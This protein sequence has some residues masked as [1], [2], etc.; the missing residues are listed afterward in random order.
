MEEL[1]PKKTWERVLT[2]IENSI[3]KPNFNTWFKDTSIARFDDG[4]IFLSVPNHFVEEWLGSKFHNLILKSLRNIST[5]IHSLQ[6]IISKDDIRKN[7]QKDKP[8]LINKELP[9]ENY[10]INREDNLNPRYTFENFIVGPFNELA[11]AAS[12]AVIKK[13][14]IVYNPLFIYGNTGHGK[15]HLIQAIGNF[16]KNVGRKVFY[17]TSEKFGQEYVNALQMNKPNFFKEKYRKYDVLIMDDIQFFSGKMKIQEELFHLFNHLYDNNR[18]II[19][20]SDK[21][22]SFIQD[23]EERLRS[24]FS[25]GMVVDIPPPEAESRMAII[26]S[27]ISQGNVEVSDEIL[28]FLSYS[29]T[30]NIR[31]IEGIVNSIVCQIQLKRRDLSL[32]EVKM[33]I[34]NSTKPKKNISTKEIVKTVA[35]FYNIEENLIYEKTRKKEIIKPRQIIMYLLREEFAISYPAIGERL[36]GRDHTTVMHSCDK[37]KRDLEKDQNLSTEIDQ[38]RSILV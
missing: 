31:E 7:N 22:P 2:E 32:N 26:Q 14:G 17:T 10:Y 19:F 37:I 23:L 25:A 9:L 11:H 35:D 29:I 34:K 15:T 33:F 36:G 20:S 24:R 5:S 21:H 8:I 4:V 27:K 16:I 6:Y 1:E 18:Q 3:S 28:N 38:L 30:G 12:Q 13:P